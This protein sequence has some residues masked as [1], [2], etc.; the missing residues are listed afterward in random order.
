MAGRDRA[1]GRTPVRVKPRVGGR[2]RPPADTDIAARRA[3]VR[4][5]I[6]P[7]VEAAGYDL[8]EFAV[9]RAGRRHLVRVLVDGDGGVDLDEVA[10]LS[11]DLS[12]AL[13]EA[14]RTRGEL[15]AGEYVLEVGSPGVDRPLTHPRHWRR[16]VGRLVAVSAAGDR[17]TGR[18]S[19][20]DEEQVTLDV[21]GV[22][23]RFGYADLGPGRVQIEFSRLDELSDD[24]EEEDEE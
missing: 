17:L 5:V 8:E 21:A 13:D 18:I 7:V 1:A 9:S 15:F 6:E 10:D 14:E 2:T 3:L 4:A 11:R 19:A 12:A 16:N 20:A 23:R 22:P 24:D